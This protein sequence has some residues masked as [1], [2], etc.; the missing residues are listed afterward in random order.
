MARL[1]YLYLNEGFWDGCSIIPSEYVRASVRQQ[2]DGGA[3]EH[4]GYGFLWWVRSEQGERAFF[5][6][7]YG[8]QLIYVVPSLDLVVVIATTSEG[9]PSTHHRT[10]IP[11]FILPAVRA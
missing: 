1:G 6:A 9:G 3:P 2:S 11:R 4:T 10:I 7:G 5:A 8:G